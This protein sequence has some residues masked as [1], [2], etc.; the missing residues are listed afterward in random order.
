MK[1][2]KNLKSFLASLFRVRRQVTEQ[3]PIKVDAAI[4]RKRRDLC[5]SCDMYASHVDTCME[6]FC[7]VRI[8]TALVTESCPLR[9]W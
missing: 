4:R 3:E 7:V 1:I 2:L 9:H 8:K 6:C 5:K